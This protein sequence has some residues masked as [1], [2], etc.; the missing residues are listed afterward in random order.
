MMVRTFGVPELQ[1]RELLTSGKAAHTSE[2]SEKVEK[3]QKKK[4]SKW[5]SWRVSNI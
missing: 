1:R 4:F 3:K 5:K 2:A